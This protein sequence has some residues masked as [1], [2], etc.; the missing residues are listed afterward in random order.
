MEFTPGEKTGQEDWRVVSK[1]WETWSGGKGGMREGVPEEMMG[2]PY[3]KEQGKEGAQ[4]V[5][6]AE[7]T[8]CARA[9]W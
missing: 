8:D 9:L 2:V 5:F 1:L 6:L 7:R 4:I 3:E